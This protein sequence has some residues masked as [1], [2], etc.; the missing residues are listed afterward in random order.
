MSVPRYAGVPGRVQEPGATDR[1][2][3]DL[4][5]LTCLWPGQDVDAMS[6]LRG[7]VQCVLW[8]EEST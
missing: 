1:L 6:R 4:E 7:R 2:V 8:A 3:R 5:Q